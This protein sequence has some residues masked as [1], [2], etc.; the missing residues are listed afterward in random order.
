MN[1]SPLSL[2][3]KIVNIILHVKMDYTLNVWSHLHAVVKFYLRQLS[4]IKLCPSI[5]TL[6]RIFIFLWP[7]IINTEGLLYGISQISILHWINCASKQE[8]V[9]YFGL[10]IQY[11]GSNTKLTIFLPS[12]S[13]K[14]FRGFIFIYD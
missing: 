7:F 4:E 1:V 5:A 14:I 12:F 6:R 2:F 11:W 9:P 8:H 13:H 3:K 10:L